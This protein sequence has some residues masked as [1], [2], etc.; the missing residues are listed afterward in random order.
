MDIHAHNIIKRARDTLVDGLVLDTVV[1]SSRSAARRAAIVGH[2]V[3][4]EQ[5][6]QIEQ[7]ERLLWD[8]LSDDPEPPFCRWCA[9]PIMQVGRGRPRLFCSS[10]CRQAE[11]RF[12]TQEALLPEPWEQAG[13]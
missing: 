11:W 1:P 9:E 8:L 12:R 4:V 3:T 5:L 2:G 10:P 7:I 6:Q 13:T